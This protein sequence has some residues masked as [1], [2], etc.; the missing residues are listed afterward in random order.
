MTDTLLY[1]IK[2]HNSFKKDYKKIIK[3][4]YKAELLEE[5][6]NYLTKGETLPPKFY[7]LN[8]KTISL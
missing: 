4:G 8:L 3:R 5:V 6:L 7:L 1:T 2:Y